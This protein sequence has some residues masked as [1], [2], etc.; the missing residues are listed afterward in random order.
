MRL[1]V[2]DFDGTIA[3]S[4]FHIMQAVKTVCQDMGLVPPKLSDVLKYTGLSVQDALA[5][6]NPHMDIH[7]RQEWERRFNTVISQPHGADTERLFDGAKDTLQALQNTGAYV[8]IITGKSRKGLDASLHA[9]GLQGMFVDTKT[10]D[11]G[12]RKPKPD[13]LQ[14]VMRDFDVS[15]DAT[16]MIGDTTYDI[17]CGKNAGTKTIGVSYGNH[18]VADLQDVGADIIV[19]TF[20]DIPR[21]IDAVFNDDR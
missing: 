17:L 19:D 3:D 1:I 15:P 7:I 9:L 14:N 10:V 21:A 12:V 11:E 5:C 16:V 4:K 20:T 2:F 6:T 13:I 8:T 18:A